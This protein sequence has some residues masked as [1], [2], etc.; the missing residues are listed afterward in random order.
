MHLR[1]SNRPITPKISTSSPNVQMNDTDI[2]M[3]KTNILNVG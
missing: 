2:V 3:L 1:P